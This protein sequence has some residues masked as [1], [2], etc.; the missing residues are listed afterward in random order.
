MSPREC[1]IAVNFPEGSQA[2]PQWTVLSLLALHESATR[3][4]HPLLWCVLMLLGY[5]DES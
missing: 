5:A 4:V 1:P 3:N 2:S